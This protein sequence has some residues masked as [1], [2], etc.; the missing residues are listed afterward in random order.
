MKLHPLRF[1]LRI[2]EDIFLIVE[3][4]HHSFAC[5][6]FKFF[7]GISGYRVTLMC[8]LNMF[9]HGFGLLCFQY[10]LVEI[11]SNIF[12]TNSVSVILSRRFSFFSS[13]N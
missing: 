5:L 13:L 2:S 6:F 1:P 9:I 11:S 7:S 10:F 4:Q 12:K 8:H 3:G